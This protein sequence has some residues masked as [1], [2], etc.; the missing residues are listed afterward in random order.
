MHASVGRNSLQEVLPKLENSVSRGCS[1]QQNRD[2]VLLGCD[3][4]YGC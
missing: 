4:D 3:H 1:M 2:C